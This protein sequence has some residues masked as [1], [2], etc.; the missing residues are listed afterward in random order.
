MNNKRNQQ[1][2]PVATVIN[3]LGRRDERAIL[4]DI[5][6]CV[7][8]IY[9]LNLNNIFIYFDINKIY[10]KDIIRHLKV[11]AWHFSFAG[12]ANRVDPTLQH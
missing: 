10:V 5:L 12:L 8:I 11:Q 6:C 2:S 4:I 1:R 7:Y 3:S 9:F